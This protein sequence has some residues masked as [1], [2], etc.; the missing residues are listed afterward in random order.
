[1]SGPSDGCRKVWFFMRN[2]TDE[3]LFV[4]TGSRPVRQPNQ[5]YGLVRMDLYKLQPLCQVV[6]QL[7]HGGLMGAIL[8]R[9]FLSATEINTRICEVH[10]HGD[11][12]NLGTAPLREGVDSPWVSPLEPN[13]SYMCQ[14]RFLKVFA[15]L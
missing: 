12:L 15:L 6:Q 3:P 5:G 8:L 10:A 13:F 14:F 1:M 4:F 11:V 7:L 2:D 9:A